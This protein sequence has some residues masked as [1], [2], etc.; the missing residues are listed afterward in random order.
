V[1]EEDAKFVSIAG[2]V[3]SVYHNQNKQLK[4]GTKPTIASVV[5][6]N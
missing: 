5:V 3:T 4:Q 1:E 2:G 6:V